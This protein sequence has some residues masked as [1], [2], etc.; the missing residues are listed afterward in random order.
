MT[1]VRAAFDEAVG[2]LATEA[3]DSA[4]VALGRT[5]ADAIDAADDLQ[6]DA[7]TKALYLT[8]H[9]MNVLK[10]LL[11]T[12]AA[13]RDVGGAAPAKG[14]TSNGKLGQLRGITGG[15]SA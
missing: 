8:P 3:V 6:G 9:L 14:A 4:A 10:E 12:P 15:R 5:L 13:R 1:G 7:R 2:A 11:A